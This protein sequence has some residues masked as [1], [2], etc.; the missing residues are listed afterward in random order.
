MKDF[1]HSEIRSL[2]VR[3]DLFHDF[4]IT[5]VLFN[6]GQLRW[7]FCVWLTFRERTVDYVIKKWNMSYIVGIK[8]KSF[9]EDPFQIET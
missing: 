5:Y 3:N 7:F 8:F 6:T 1:L 4:L 9:K 2:T